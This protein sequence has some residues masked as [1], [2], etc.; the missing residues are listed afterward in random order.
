MRALAESRHRIRLW[1]R[2]PQIGDAQMALLGEKPHE[3]TISLIDFGS[4]YGGV[5]SEY[6]TLLGRPSS[7]EG[8]K[9]GLDTGQLPL[10][11]GIYWGPYLLDAAKNWPELWSSSTRPP[12]SFVRAELT[13]R[14]PPEDL[15]AVLGRD[16]THKITMAGKRDVRTWYGEDPQHQI[17]TERAILTHGHDDHVGSAPYLL[18]PYLLTYLTAGYL[19][20]LSRRD[21]WQ[22][23][24]EKL[25]FLGL[26]PKIGAAYQIEGRPMQRVYHEGEEVTLDSGVKVTFYNVDHS[27]RGSAMLGFETPDGG[28]FLYSGDIGLGKLTDQALELAARAKYP[29]ILWEYTNDPDTNKSSIEL[30]PEEVYANFLAVMRDRANK[31]KLIVVMMPPNEQDRLALICRAAKVAHRSVVVG[32]QMANTLDRL[33]EEIAWAPSGAAQSDWFLPVLGRDLWLWSPPMKTR[34]TWQQ[35][36]ERTAGDSLVTIN[37]LQR[38]RGD[39]VLVLSPYDNLIK[40]IG[41]ADVSGLSVIYSA[42]FPYREDDKHRVAALRNF[43]TSRGG[44]WYADFVIYG[45]GGRVIPVPPDEAAWHC[46]GHAFFPKNMEMLAVIAPPRATIYFVHGQHLER[47]ALAAREWFKK[48]KKR[49]DLKFVDYLDHVDS[50]RPHERPGHTIHLNS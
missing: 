4:V 46:S 12:V 35:D 31:G 25:S 43:T 16:N 48:M 6:T 29:I 37:T 13:R 40:A 24:H 23:N 38:V 34:D 47:Y 28:K 9:R 27:I 30:T 33:S 14:F 15:I 1:Y 17:T 32:Y 39:V 45:D 50:L 49:T 3:T 11:P 19:R 36:L 18:S 7:V 8:I 41:G 22:R 10:Q 42:P 44:R 21:G 20:A 2:G 26:K 5:P